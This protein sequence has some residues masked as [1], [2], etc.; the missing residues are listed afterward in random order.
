MIEAKKSVAILP[1]GAE[2]LGISPWDQHNQKLVGFVHPLDHKNP[3]PAEK[4]KLVVV[5]A[6]PAGLVTA[7]A[8]AGLGAKVALVERHLMGGDCLNVGCVPSKALIRAG[9]AAAAI[10]RAKDFGIEVEGKVRVDFGKV[11]ERLRRLRAD[12]A[13]HDSVARFAELGIDVFVGTG[14]FTGRNTVEVDGKTLRFDKACIATG[15]RP[16][17]PPIPGLKETGFLTNEQVF[18]LTEMPRRLA[19]IGAG[20]IGCELSQAFARF[21]CQVSLVDMSEQ[22]LGREDQDAAKIVQQALVEDGVD[23]V[24][25]AK[26]QKVEARGG[27]KVMTLEVGGVTR[28]LE[29]DEI[30]VG[31]GRA[32]NVQGLGLEEAG[33]QYDPKSGVKVDDFLR[34]ANPDV[35]AAG[36]VCFPYKFTHTADF[37]ARAVIR[38][39]LFPFGR[40][41]ASSLNIPWVTYT[42]PEIA[43]VGMYEKDAQSRG[44]KVDTYTVAL[45]GV[46]RAILEGDTEGFVKVHT[47]KGTGVIL[48]ATIVGEHAGEMISEVTVAMKAKMSLGDLANV[49]HPYPTTADAIRK[50]GDLFNKTKLTPTARK[51]MAWL[52]K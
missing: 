44:L 24:L 15:A 4:Y 10:T 39:A 43:H 6:G 41:R 36:D 3:E 11:M 2:N 51:V 48:G 19:V 7:I 27:V 35:F 28:T 21:G 49:I 30:L 18:N 8:S 50:T 52:L 34:T 9:R 16:W 1:S 45:S 12:M 47:K 14:T 5:G 20:P 38:N 29:V 13:H 25:G 32:P 37:L 46:D 17:A 31:A 23:L 42:D 22:I 40:A 26:T 33:V